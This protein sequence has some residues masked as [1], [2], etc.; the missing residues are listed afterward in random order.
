MTYSGRVA[1]REVEKLALTP[2]EWAVTLLIAA[3]QFTN[4]LDFV[5]VMPLGP[6]FAKALGVAESNLGFVNGSYTA[7]AAVTGFAGSFF[8]DRFDRR[9][10]LGVALIGLVAGT[11]LCGLAS[12]FT[13]LLGARVLAG[14]FGGPA[15]SLSFS[16]IA[17]AIPARV[18]GRAMGTVMGAFS[19]AS[20]FGV[21]VGLWLSEH[22]GWRAPFFA[23]AGLG[24]VVGLSS[25]AAL[26]PMRGHLEH[27]H[28]PVSFVALL[29]Q[30]LVRL[31]YTM[32]AVVMMAGF[33]V[34]PSIAPYLR[35]NFGF[36]QEHLKWAY[37]IGGVA[38]FFATQL[39][40]R[41]VDRFGSFRVGTAGA[42]L[43][44]AVVFT[45]FYLPWTSV[46]SWAV[47][48]GFVAFMLANGIRNVSYNTLTSK[49]PG[50]EVRA[51]FQS[52]Q[53][54]VQHAASALAAWG[55]TRMMTTVP[56][57][58]DD[59]TREPRMMVGMDRVALV[60]MGL[61]F[62]I[63][64]LLWMVERSVKARQRAAKVVP[65]VPSPA[66]SA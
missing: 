47:V 51:R 26:P 64:V 33:L 42:V 16:I 12:D 39:G 35:L 28:A 65:R 54:S 24:V 53:S 49:V 55:S 2:R 59:A 56:R 20:V 34:I 52:L 3:V 31:S 30:P 38:S 9:K 1:N 40:G 7:A 61:S 27:R 11:T 57:A 63:P 37:G 25:I 36:P 5:I 66:T 19:V 23:V 17:D 4:I 41:L 21:P 8:L 18:R 45:E 13:L 62:L 60:S 14:A 32:T 22:F 43:V 46:P 6:A 44:I 50:P 29:Q 10:A 48:G 58:W 15:T